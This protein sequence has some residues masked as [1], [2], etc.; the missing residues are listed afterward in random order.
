MF[1]PSP[2]GRHRYLI[3]DP[4]Q[5]EQIIQTYTEIASAKPVPKA[6]RVFGQNKKQQQPQ[7]K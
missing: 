3:L 2:G 4:A 7:K 5:K 6:P 1:T